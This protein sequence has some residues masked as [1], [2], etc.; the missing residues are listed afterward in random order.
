M[1]GSLCFSDSYGN[2]QLTLKSV[3]ALERILLSLNVPTIFFT[4]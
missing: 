4:F 1:F 3:N 2:L